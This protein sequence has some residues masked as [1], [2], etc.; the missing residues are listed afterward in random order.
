[1]LTVNGM[2]EAGEIR[3][4]ATIGRGLN[5]DEITDMLMARLIY[6]ADT[7]APVI[8]AQAQAFKSDI[9]GLVLHYVRQAQKSQNTSTYNYL[10]QAGHLDAAELVRKL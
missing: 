2:I 4:T 1:M 7:A 6:V 3:A 9:R 5:A 10:M 8:Q